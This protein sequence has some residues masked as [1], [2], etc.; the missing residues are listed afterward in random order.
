ML[1]SEDPKLPKRVLHTYHDG[2]HLQ[3]RLY[4]SKPGERAQ[5]TTL[6][7]CWGDNQ[8][9]TTTSTNDEQHCDKIDW[10]LLPKTFQDA[11]IITHGLGLQYLWI[12]SLCIVQDS[13]N[14]WREQSAIMKDI[15]GY[16]YVTIAA[17]A[18]DAFE[19]GLHLLER[20][21]KDKVFACRTE[22]LTLDKP[23]SKLFTRAWVLQERLLASRILYFFQGEV[24]FECSNHIRC[25]CSDVSTLSP[26]V[27]DPFEADWGM[28]RDKSPAFRDLKYR[29]TE[30]NIS[31][32]GKRLRLFASRSVTCERDLCPSLSYDENVEMLELWNEILHHYI[33]RAIT[34]TTDRLPALSGIAGAFGSTGAHGIYHA[35][36]WET[37]F[38]HMLLWYVDQAEWKGMTP[39]PFTAE[40]LDTL[41]APSWSWAKLRG[42][43]TYRTRPY[44]RVV[45]AEMV[46]STVHLVSEDRFGSVYSDVVTVKGL[47]MEVQLKY[48]SVERALTYAERFQRQGV[49]LIKEKDGGVATMWP[50][51][52]LDPLVDS[53]TIVTLLAVRMHVEN[54][55]HESIDG[56]VLQ[57]VDDADGRHRRLGIFN[58]P[59]WWF[60]GSMRKSIKLS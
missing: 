54:E 18:N 35:G 57:V 44:N 8:P 1:T 30:A 20:A 34:K 12:D 50:D 46:E 39:E 2:E 9:L 13:E 29:F 49:E 7:H 47:T 37:W 24:A 43:W 21:K 53:G 11:I 5:Y 52:V 31:K 59:T 3:T 42:A 36:L 56:V 19:H 23:G 55:R 41:L 60:H 26:A 32:I 45:L 6:S 15:Y 4:E 58:A 33:R 48:G 14:D 25:Q 16:S 17:A 51:F 10:E 40:D 28:Q 22:I 27:R 38:V